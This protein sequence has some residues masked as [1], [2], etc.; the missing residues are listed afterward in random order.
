MFLTHRNVSKKT[1]T[2]KKLLE[3]FISLVTIKKKNVSFQ[4][5]IFLIGN[6]ENWLFKWNGNWN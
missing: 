3:L 4:G 2:K 5:F 6:R 1:K